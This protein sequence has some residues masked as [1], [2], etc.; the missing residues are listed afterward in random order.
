[1]AYWEESVDGGTTDNDWD[2]NWVASPDDTESWDGDY[3]IAMSNTTSAVTTDTSAIDLD[4]HGASTVCLYHYHEGEGVEN[5]IGILGSGDGDNICTGVEISSDNGDFFI[6]YYD[7]GDLTKLET[8]EITSTSDQWWRFEMDIE[9]VDDT[10]YDLTGRVYDASGSEETLVKEFSVYTLTDGQTDFGTS[11]PVTLIDEE[12]W[13]GESYYDAMSVEELSTETEQLVLTFDASSTSSFDSSIDKSRSL[14][15]SPSGSSTGTIE[16]TKKRSVSM[17]SSGGGKL[18]GWYYSTPDPIDTVDITIPEDSTDSTT[19]EWETS[20]TDSGLYNVEVSTTNEFDY[21]N[22]TIETGALSLKFDASSTSSLSID[23]NKVRSITAS[24]A[25]TSTL[26]ATTDKTRSITA[27]MN[28]SGDAVASLNKVRSI[29]ASP[30]GSSTLSSDT[31]KIRAI[32]ASAD[33]SGDASIATNKARSIS[34]SPSST[35]NLSASVD[36]TRSLQFSASGSS[37]VDVYLDIVSGILMSMTASSNTNIVESGFS[38]ETPTLQAGKTTFLDESGFAGEN[39]DVEVLSVHNLQSSARAAESASAIADVTQ[40]IL[41]FVTGGDKEILSMVTSST[42]SLESDGIATESPSLL[43][44]NSYFFE[45]YAEAN[46]SGTV[47]ATSL[48]EF[49]EKY[50]V[51][52][53]V[54]SLVSSNFSLIEWGEAEERG[55]VLSVSNSN[56]VESISVSSS[57]FVVGDKLVTINEVVDYSGDTL[58]RMI[59]RDLDFDASAVQRTVEFNTD[60]KR[61]LD[62]NE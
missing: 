17:T 4:D 26:S 9:P 20:D 18:A 35:S 40:S 14:T 49:G 62:M 10:D 57:L 60:V 53:Q 8:H 5:G 55:D 43:S 28:G 48:N 33:G 34:V 27:S 12:Q 15:V 16:T 38:T 22:A 24:P 13:S 30:S 1:M 51:L 52:E 2:P 42:T 54:E 61:I 37:N 44:E 59:V 45:E 46:E 36:K 6:G 32:S 3:S 50:K 31:N 58:K 19:L 29:S 41:E 7:G 23:T 21:E 39:L 25:S 47:T 11:G 56:I